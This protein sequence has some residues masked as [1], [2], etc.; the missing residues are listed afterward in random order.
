MF[1]GVVKFFV[2]IKCVIFVWKV[3]GKVMEN[4]GIV[5]FYYYYKEEE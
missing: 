1:G 3:L 5:V 2:W 4:D